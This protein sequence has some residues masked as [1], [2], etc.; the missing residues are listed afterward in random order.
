M[1]A[2]TFLGLKKQIT[3]EV[4]NLILSVDKKQ[5]FK[6]TLKVKQEISTNEVKW[7]FAMAFTFFNLL[8]FG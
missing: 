8:A 6:K 4:F 5:I 7:L 2:S 3:S 1:S